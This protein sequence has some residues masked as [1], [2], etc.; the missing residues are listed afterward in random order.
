LPDSAIKRKQDGKIWLKSC[1]R[2]GW[3]K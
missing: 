3:V 1:F 2:G